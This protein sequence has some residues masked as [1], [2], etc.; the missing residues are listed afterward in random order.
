MNR[1]VSFSMIASLGFILMVSLMLNS[2]LKVLS[3]RLLNF[4]NIE[5]INLVMLINSSDEKELSPK[6][7]E[8]KNAV[9]KTETNCD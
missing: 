6:E 2:V 8:V 3:N 1:L 4:L 7:V 5:Q 9:E